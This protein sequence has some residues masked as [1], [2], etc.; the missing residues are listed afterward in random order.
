MKERV[1]KTEN[2]VMSSHHYNN[3]SNYRLFPFM[4]VLKDMRPCTQTV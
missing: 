3:K 1:L 2:G 4:V